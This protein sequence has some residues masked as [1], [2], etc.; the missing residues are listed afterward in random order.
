MVKRCPFDGRRCFRSSCDFISPRGDVLVC[1]RH[2]NPNGRFR[3]KKFVSVFE[4]RLWYW[5]LPR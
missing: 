1:S 5:R 3:S 2:L 4:G